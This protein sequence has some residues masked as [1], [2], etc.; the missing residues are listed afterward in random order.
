DL[1]SVGGRVFDAET[2]EVIRPEALPSISRAIP[3]RDRLLVVEAKNRVTAWKSV[4]KAAEAPPLRLLATGGAA[5]PEVPPAHAALDDGRVVA[6]GFVLDAKAGALR[7]SG[8]PGDAGSW[9]LATVRALLTD[10]SPRRLL[11]ASRPDLAAA[12]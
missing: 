12:G 10:A 1:V 11:L 5:P 7:G 3:L 4:K 8:K 9:P 2:L 6:G